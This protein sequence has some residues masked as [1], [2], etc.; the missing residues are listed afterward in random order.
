MALSALATSPPSTLAYFLPLLLSTTPSLSIC[1]FLFLQ[2]HLLIHSTSFLGKLSPVSAFYTPLPSPSSPP[3]HLWPFPAQFT[4]LHANLLQSL[5]LSCTPT[6]LKS[7]LLPFC[8]YLVGARLVSGSTRFST[9]NIF[10][11]SSKKF[12][13]HLFTLFSH[14]TSFLP[15]TVPI[16]VS[17][18]TFNVYPIRTTFVYCSTCILHP[19]V[20]V[21]FFLPIS[22]DFLAIHLADFAPR[23]TLHPPPTNT[24]CPP[25]NF[26]LG[27]L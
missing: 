24:S 8:I 19:S 23:A 13:S 11:F 17:I 18:K 1:C 26:S 5:A 14:V 12:S 9:P 25:I 4:Y 22:P 10:R 15:L 21:R 27:L 2:S 7:L 6:N 20:S 16:H 3:C